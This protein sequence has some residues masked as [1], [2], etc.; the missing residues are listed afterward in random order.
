MLQACN[1]KGEKQVMVPEVTVVTAQSS[2]LPI[3]VEYVGQAYGLSDVLIQARVQ[4]L[5]TGMYFKEGKYVKEGDL[6]YTIDD[7]PYQAK[8]SEADGKLADAKSELTRAENDLARIKPLVE[9]NALS[10]RDLDAA[11]AAVSAA[12]GRVKAANASK[13]NALIELGYCKVTS[14]V[15][16]VIGISQVR[17]GDF[18]GSFNTKSLNTISDITQMRIRF[19]ISENDYL[20]FMEIHKKRNIETDTAKQV[21]VDLY[22]SNGEKYSEQGIFNIANREI[23]PTTGTLTIEALVSNKESMLRPG[24]YIKVKFP[25]ELMNDAIIIPQRAVLQIQNIFQVCVLGDSNKVAMRTI[26]V[27]PRIGEWWVI[28]EGIQ[29]NEKIVLLGNKV[30][31]PNSVVKPIF[32]DSTMQLQVK[33]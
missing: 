14:P 15:S 20:H 8:V 24:Q 21:K 11:V 27:G 7:M 28:T 17:V 25:S 6:L 30:V 32:A 23:D 12:E 2:D 9:S 31:K 29:P 10:K 13:S 1:K 4:G 22:L 5:I 3:Y 33:P 19:P 18:V 26:K 16:G